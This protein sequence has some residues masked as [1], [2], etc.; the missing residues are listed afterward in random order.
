MRMPHRS[1]R[2]HR[3]R[4]DGAG[5]ARVAMK[6]ESNPESRATGAEAAAR[7][8]EHFRAHRDWSLR[9]VRAGAGQR[10]RSRALQAV[11]VPRALDAVTLQLALRRLLAVPGGSVV[12][13]PLC[14]MPLTRQA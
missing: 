6:R 7:S 12:L 8:N 9:A 14:P 5:Q 1:S 2:L 10:R 13:A 3:S 11:V 4:P